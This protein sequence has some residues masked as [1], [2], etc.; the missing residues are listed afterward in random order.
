MR[1][2]LCRLN[3]GNYKETTF[4]YSATASYAPT[5]RFSTATSV[6]FQ[7][8]SAE[9]NALFTFGSSMISPIYKTIVGTTASTRTVD[10]HKSPG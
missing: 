1:R 6:G 2:V 7:F 9:E 4:D 5:G 8:N 3:R 10:Q